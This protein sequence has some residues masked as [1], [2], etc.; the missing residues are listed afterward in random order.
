MKKTWVLA[1]LIC[2][3]ATAQKSNLQLESVFTEVN[4]KVVEWRRYFHEYPELGNREFNTSKKVE[5]TLQRLGISTRK[6][7]KTGIVDRKSVV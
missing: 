4:P 6:M 3:T 2:G 5:E 7:A 1:L